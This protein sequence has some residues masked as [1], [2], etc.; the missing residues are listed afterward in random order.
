MDVTAE[1][2]ANVSTTRTPDGGP[3]QKKAVMVEAKNASPSFD[4]V[5]KAKD[6]QLPKVAGIE[7]SNNPPIKIYDPGHPDA[8]DRGFV[9]MPDISA[10]QEM[11][12]MMQASTAYE[13]NVTVFNA[14]KSMVLRT[15]ELGGV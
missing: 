10:T 12:D 7:K 4:D 1:N 3:Y 2:L 8:D 15:L 11:I 13:A 5:L 6:V 14:A 9:A